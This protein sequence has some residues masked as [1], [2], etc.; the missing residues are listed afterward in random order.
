MFMPFGGLK[1]K[2]ET[3]KT[4]YENASCEPSKP[5]YFARQLIKDFF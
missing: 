4:A 3:K 1:K 5:T 2:K